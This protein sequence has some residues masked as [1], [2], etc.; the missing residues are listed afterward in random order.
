MNS[1][2]S[3]SRVLISFRLLYSLSAW[4]LAGGTL[5][6]IY[7]V[8]LSLFK[9]QDYWLWHKE[10]GFTLGI[11]VPVLTLLALFARIPRN[12]AAMLVLIVV[13]YFFQIITP[14]F[15]G[16]SSWAAAL[17]PINAIVLIWVSMVH[18]RKV[19]A[20]TTATWKSRRRKQQA[21]DSIEESIEG[22]V[23]TN[24]Q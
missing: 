10:I 12:L 3:P 2:Q 19:T 1:E 4:L 11:L 6:P 22:S 9:S 7:L 16:S 8:G 15:R 24:P 5:V 23:T 14:W 13:L 20:L 21:V 18:A 17:H